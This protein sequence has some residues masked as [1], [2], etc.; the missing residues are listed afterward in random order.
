MLEEKEVADEH[1][2]KYHTMPKTQFIGEIVN[3]WKEIYVNWMDLARLSLH[4]YSKWRSVELSSLQQMEINH[5][6]KY[7]S[8]YSPP[9]TCGRRHRLIRKMESGGNAME[10]IMYLFSV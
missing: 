3:P 1:G 6:M 2:C 4:L 9:Q 7:L 10:E 8:R 5:T